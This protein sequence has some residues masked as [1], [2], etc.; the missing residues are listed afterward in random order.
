MEV[1]N[2]ARAVVIFRVQK[3]MNSF[4][5]GGEKNYNSRW[6]AALLACLVF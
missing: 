5:G 3:Y 4:W 2:S 1:I 6:V